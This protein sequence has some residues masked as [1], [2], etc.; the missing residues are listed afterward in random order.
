MYRTKIMLHESSILL[1]EHTNF[2]LLR[3]LHFGMSHNASLDCYLEFQNGSFLKRTLDISCVYTVIRFQT[4]KGICKNSCTSTYQLARDV[5]EN[6]VIKK[7]LHKFS[8][9]SLMQLFQVWFQLIL[10]GRCHLF[11]SWSSWILWKKKTLSSTRW[12]KDFK[13]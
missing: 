13:F 3:S 9:F 1:Q 2:N 12:R 7:E 5:G 11:F 8:Y 10:F 4:W 6:S